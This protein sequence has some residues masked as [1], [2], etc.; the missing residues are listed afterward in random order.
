MERHSGSWEKNIASYIMF[1]KSL[2]WRDGDD[3]AVDVDDDHIRGGGALRRWI[4]AA[5]PPFDLL[6]RQSSVSLFLFLCFCAASLRNSSGGS[7][8]KSFYVTRK[9][10][11]EG[12]SQTEPRGPKEV[13]PRG[14]VQGPRGAPSFGPPASVCLLPSLRGLPPSKK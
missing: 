11:E 6:R 5:F 4:P 14:Q 9:L 12:S 8:Y 13:G 2:Q 3:L 1:A 10:R 7:L